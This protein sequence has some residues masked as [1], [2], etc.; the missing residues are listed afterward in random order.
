MTKTDKIKRKRPA[1]RLG[2]AD[3]K[4][5][6]TPAKTAVIHLPSGAIGIAEVGATNAVASAVQAIVDCDEFAAWEKAQLVAM[7]TA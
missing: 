4:I 3:F 5:Y 7:V 2:L 6:E 1:V